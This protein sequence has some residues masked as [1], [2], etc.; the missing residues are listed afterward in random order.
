M[1]TYSQL[2]FYEGDMFMQDH[3]L[4]E[5]ADQYEVTSV[6]YIGDSDYIESVLG[7]VALTQHNLCVYIVNSYFNFDHVVDT[8]NQ[9]LKKLPPNGFLYLSLNKFLAVPKSQDHVPNDYNV[10]IYNL[11]GK[12]VN[13]PMFRYYSGAIDCGQRFNWAHPIT[14]FIFINENFD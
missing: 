14:R 8:C 7:R 6:K 5:F 10:A 1:N 3:D 11:I 12:G 2:D 9:E 4:V 13:A